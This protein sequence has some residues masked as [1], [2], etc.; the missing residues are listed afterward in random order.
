MKTQI[1]R[2]LTLSLAASLAPATF[3]AVTINGVQFDRF[4]I[5]AAA[6]GDVT[7]TTVPAAAAGT[8]PAILPK[9]VFDISMTSLPGVEGTTNIDTIPGPGAEGGFTPV[10]CVATPL[11]PACPIIPP[12][13]PPGEC[14]DIG[15]PLVFETIPWTALPNKI[16]LTTGKVGAASKFTTSLS[17][18][19]KGYFSGLATTAS[20]NLSRRMWFSECPGAAPIVRNYTI[21]GDVR[22]ACDV[23][24]VDLKLSWSQENTPAYVT[25]CKLTRGKTY[26]L[27]YS[28]A[29]FGTGSGP[30]TTSQLIRGAGK[31]GT[32]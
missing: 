24:G 18:T 13:P 11:D 22:N 15:A 19:Y 23:S 10:N 1:L 28:Q 32:P 6:N 29:A 5:S 31:S 17:T 26:Y 30:T 2:L 16:V 8:I 12:P 27:N 7:L 14:G 3:A 4:S 21:G 9:K 25:T 20:A